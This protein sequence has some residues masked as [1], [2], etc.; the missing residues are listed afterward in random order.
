MKKLTL[1]LLTASLLVTTGCVSSGGG[2]NMEGLMNAGTSLA[3][4]A[5]LTDSDIQVLGDRTIQQSDAENRVAAANSRYGQRLANLTRNWQTVNGMRFDYRVYLQDEVNAFA[6]PNGSIRVYSGLLDAYSDDEVRYVLAHEIGHVMMGHSK[7]ALQVAYTANAARAAAASAG[8]ATIAALS[9]S[10]I[11][12]LGESLVNAQ[13]SQ[14]QEN[15]ADDF[16]IGFMRDQGLNARAAVTALRKMERAFGNNS[17]MF[18]SHPAPGARADRIE[19]QLAR[20]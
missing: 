16:A 7:R 19:Q 20:R 9:S 14:R 3:T 2:F 6:V 11:G 4:A 12:E 8:N 18:S 13:F 1:G 5:T 17:N 10:A 15:E